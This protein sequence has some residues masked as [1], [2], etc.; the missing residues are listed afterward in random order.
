MASQLLSL[1][2]YAR[3][4]RDAGLAG[5]S[6]SA[7]QRAIADRRIPFTVRGGRKLIDPE[8][9]DAAWD[10]NTR[11]KADAGPPAEGGEPKGG[12]KGNGGQ[13]AAHRNEYQGARAEKER[14]DVELKRLELLQKQGELLDAATVR[15][16]AFELGRRTRDRVLA[17]PARLASSLRAALK[18]DDDRAVERLLDAELRAALKDL[19]TD[20]RSR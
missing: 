14:L 16:E 1:R 7:V 18:E 17:I 2:A 5:Y 19:V 20:E 12:A 15:K 3:H 10:A 4:R 8:A 11:H 9:A 6:L 13:G